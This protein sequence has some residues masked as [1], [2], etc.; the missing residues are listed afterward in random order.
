MSPCDL[1]CVD[2]DRCPSG[3]TCSNGFCRTPGDET[4]CDPPPVRQFE[5]TV[6]LTGS[7]TN[8]VF[9]PPGL[10]CTETCTVTL[11]EG[12]H[13]LAAETEDNSRVLEWLGTTCDAGKAECI[14]TLDSDLAVDVTFGAAHTL[15]IVRTGD[16]EG[17]L[18]G[19]SDDPLQPTFA[20]PDTVCIERFAEGSKVTLTKI[21]TE[22]AKSTWS[23]DCIGMPPT[24]PCEI[25][26]DGSSKSAVADFR[27]LNVTLVVAPAGME[28]KPDFD[29]NLCSGT[30]VYTLSPDIAG[31]PQTLTAQPPT[32]INASH[33][34]D[35]WLT[36]DAGVCEGRTDLDC[37][38]PLVDDLVLIALFE[39]RPEVTVFFNSPAG[40]IAL[41]TVDPPTNGF[42]CM[43]PI[44]GSGQGVCTVRVDKGS[45]VTFKGNP[46]SAF[47]EA[48]WVN[49]PSQPGPPFDPLCTLDDVVDD[50]AFSAN[51]QRMPRLDAS[52]VTGG[53]EVTVDGDLVRPFVGGV[54]HSS[55]TCDVDL[56]CDYFIP[57]MSVVEVD[58]LGNPAMPWAGT[59]T[60]PG[61]DPQADPCIFTITVDDVLVGF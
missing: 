50:V 55:T 21:D 9:G 28:V 7:G 6:T 58:H 47:D 43:A 45:D 2:G 27:V 46:A 51:F 18:E 54:L 26:L 59:S 34:F 13:R 31:T 42:F 17:R 25:V 60:C 23:G 24:S 35:R 1:A 53:I 38:R 30:C 39:R 11:D 32:T 36:S 44:E 33:R 12:E 49:C 10:D 20:C 56:D 37:T 3:L 40:S 48:R 19:V 57:F 22:P 16:G 15:R 41:E 14:V 8:R 5:L 29:P 61:N 4:E 52:A